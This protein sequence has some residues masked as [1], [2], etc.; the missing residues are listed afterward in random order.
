M[1]SPLT[2]NAKRSLLY[3]SSTIGISPILFSSARRGVPAEISP[4]TGTDMNVFSFLLF[5]NDLDK[6][7]FLVSKPF[8]I[9]LSKWYCTELVDLRFTA[10]AISLTEGEYPSVINLWFMYSKISD[11]L[12]ILINYNII[13]NKCSN[14]FLSYTITTI[15]L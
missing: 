6:F 10:F 5:D 13:S 1:E 9:K 14:N 4:I 8:L 3:F 2:F 7:A 12:F 15:F 11:C